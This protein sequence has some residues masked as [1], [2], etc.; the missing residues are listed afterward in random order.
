MDSF[1]Y[2]ND[3]MGENK[4]GLMPSNGL[5]IPQD[6]GNHLFSSNPSKKTNEISEESI[7]ENLFSEY[8]K[9]TNQNDKPNDLIKN[10]DLNSFKLSKK[11]KTD[12]QENESNSSFSIKRKR[13]S[14]SSEILIK[15][16][17]IKKG[18]KKIIIDIFP[19]N[20]PKFNENKSDDLNLMV[21]EE[22]EIN[23]TSIQLIDQN[24]KNDNAPTQKKN[25]EEEKEPNLI[26][27]EN[28][29]YGDCI[30]INKESF[31]KDKRVDNEII[32]LKKW[33]F[34]HF[35]NEIKEKINKKFKITLN[36]PEEI[37]SIKKELNLKLLTMKWKDLLIWEQIIEDLKRQ[38]KN[39]LN[40]E[41]NE[42]FISKKDKKEAKKLLELTFHQ[43][44]LNNLEQFCSQE[45]DTQ[46]EKCKNNK[47]RAI[48]EELVKNRKVNE[49]E[50]IKTFIYFEDKN[51]KK[52]KKNNII[53]KIKE[54]IIELF[55]NHYIK[56]KKEN[57]D[58][59]ES[60]FRTLNYDISTI[61]EEDKK[62]IE[63]DIKCLKK[64]AENLNI[65]F[66]KSDRNK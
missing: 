39:E 18:I 50:K 66:S 8:N 6:Q 52:E 3:F 51:N 46:I 65:F 37:E 11:N 36:A 45:F 9:E 19:E 7:T 13:E 62:R 10:F 26:E 27:E 44:M 4:N 15:D 43:Y 58:K 53:F 38:Q 61:S 56:I 31:V 40:G 47:C 41:N 49:L 55:R 17:G 57:M 12:P 16:K 5:N 21:N 22:N 25:L 34:Y 23:K 60:L 30:Q 63:N 54:D 29:Q 48:I 32:K 14:Q 59:L 1:P 24:I 42:I 20:I 35:V 2:L 33:T 64:L 28:L